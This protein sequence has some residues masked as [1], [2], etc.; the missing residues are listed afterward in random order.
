MTAGSSLTV[1]SET[2]VFLPEKAAR[3]KLSKIFGSLG[4][5]LFSE[6]Q[7]EF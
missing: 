7:L 6:L 4:D 1:D 5:V 3:E 2:L